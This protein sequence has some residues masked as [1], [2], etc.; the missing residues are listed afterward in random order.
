MPRLC[1]LDAVR[2]ILN[3]DC[4]YSLYA[5]CDLAPGLR[6]H[7]EWI[8]SEGKGALALVFRMFETPILFAIGA[9]EELEGV[10][11]EVP[12]CC[13]Y[14]LHV[15]PGALEVMR[16]RFRIVEWHSM[17]RMVLGELAEPARPV[18]PVRLGVGDLAAVQHVYADGAEAG[19]AP[20]FFHEASLG[21]GVFFGVFEEGEVVSVA[22]THLFDREQG[23]AAIGN[24]YTRRGRRGLGLGAAVTAA[25][26]RKLREEGAKLIGLNVAET[27]TRAIGV[28]RR[29][30]FEVHCRFIEGR[31]AA[32]CPTDASGE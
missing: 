23:I 8:Q 17:L 11:A 26:A 12:G 13:E 21:S 5:L 9:E 2:R 10:L 6:E 1:D 32:R 16:R 14:S 22:G 15:R 19:E 18:Q 30:G 27:N 29:L 25:V 24:V 31:T 3:S 28:Y 20:P 4:G 7:A